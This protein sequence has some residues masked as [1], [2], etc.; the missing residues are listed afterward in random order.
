MTPSLD[1]S[2]GPGDE[3]HELIDALRGFALAGVLLVNLATLSLCDMLPGPARE[4]MPTAGFDAVVAQAMSWLVNVEFITLFTL[5]FGVGFALQL[6]RARHAATAC[7]CMS[8]A[9][10]CCWRSACCTAISS[11]G[12][13]SC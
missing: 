5:L 4:S 10:A 11:G 3:R 1:A 8:G 2:P 7:A 6:E 9:S 12:A 13:T